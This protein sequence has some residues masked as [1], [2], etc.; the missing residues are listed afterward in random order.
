MSLHNGTKT[1]VL[2]GPHWSSYG[3]IRLVTSLRKVKAQTR[4]GLDPSKTPFSQPKPV[5][6]KLVGVPSHSEYLDRVADT[7]EEDLEVEELW[8]A[9]IW[10]SMFT[11]PT[12]KMVF[13]FPALLGA[14]KLIFYVYRV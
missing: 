1:F 8:E 6:F 5:R 13:L 10:K 2:T 11:T 14:Y 4:S 12:R 3:F 7:V 9:K